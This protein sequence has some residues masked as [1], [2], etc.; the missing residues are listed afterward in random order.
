MHASGLG[1]LSGWWPAGGCERHASLPWWVFESVGHASREERCGGLHTRVRSWFVMVRASV[2]A[3]QRLAGWAVGAGWWP[4]GRCRGST[5]ALGVL[6]HTG[7]QVCVNV[8]R[9]GLGGWHTFWQLNIGIVCVFSLPFRFYCTTVL[10]VFFFFFLHKLPCVI[11]FRFFFPTTRIETGILLLCVVM[12]F[13]TLFF[14][15]FFF[16]KKWNHE[17]R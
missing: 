6:R 7:L 4:C 12:L 3:A 11:F 2:S 1:G 10:C 17:I 16:K 9:N 14:F 13:A 8:I 15:L 5:D